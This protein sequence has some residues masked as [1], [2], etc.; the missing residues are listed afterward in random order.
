MAPPTTDQG[1]PA[2]QQSQH[3]APSVARWVTLPEFAVANKRPRLPEVEV[4]VEPELPE[5]AVERVDEDKP[6]KF[7]SWTTSARTN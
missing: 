3:N 5:D 4:T 6:H 2:V 7:S 1:T